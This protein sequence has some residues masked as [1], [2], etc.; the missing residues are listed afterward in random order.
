MVLVLVLGY[1]STMTAYSNIAKYMPRTES[2][3]DE[4]IDSIDFG[5][6]EFQA[7][8][9]YSRTSSIQGFIAYIEAQ[10]KLSECW[11][12]KGAAFLEHLQGNIKGIEENQQSMGLVVCCILLNLK[13]SSKVRYKGTTAHTMIKLEYVLTRWARCKTLK[14]ITRMS[15]TQS[16]KTS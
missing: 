3:I 8:R 13:N 9:D 4:I 11:E 6:N 2:T 15:K 10:H 12:K 1:P 7:L 5:S 14:T 16:S